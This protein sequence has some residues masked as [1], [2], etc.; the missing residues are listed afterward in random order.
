L[1]PEGNITAE[2]LEARLRQKG[3]R[4]YMIAKEFN[5][6]RKTVRALLGPAS[7]VYEGERGWLKFREP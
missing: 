7:R 5:V 4:V 6:S 1:V 3:A 2:Q